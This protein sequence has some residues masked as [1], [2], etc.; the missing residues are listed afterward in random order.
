MSVKLPIGTRKTDLCY[1]PLRGPSK[2]WDGQF[3]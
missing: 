2:P 3:E 1:G